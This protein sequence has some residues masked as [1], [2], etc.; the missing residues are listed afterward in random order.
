MLISRLGI[1]GQF[2]L[3]VLL[4]M[5]IFGSGVAYFFGHY[6][7]YEETIFDN[8]LKRQ[9]ETL[10]QQMRQ[11]AAY[12]ASNM[13]Y[14]IE[15]ALAQYDF[16]YI[17]A[18]IKKNA[19]EIP[20]F[21][22][23]YLKDKTGKVLLGS[24]EDS[25]GGA[26]LAAK[27]AADKAPLIQREAIWRGRP[28]LETRS[29]VAPDGE[30]WGSLLLGLH[31]DTLDKEIAHSVEISETVE[32]ALK[33]EQITLALASLAAFLGT[34]VILVVIVRYVTTPIRSL[35]ASVAGISQDMAQAEI[36]VFGR[37]DE[38][39]VLSR[40]FKE[41]VERIRSYISDLTEMNLSLERKVAER[42]LDLERKADELAE[43]NA[44]IIDGITCAQEVQK[45]ILPS[46]Q[47]LRTFLADSFV[48]W[49]PK[50]IVGGDFYWFDSFPAGSLVAVVD[51]TGHGVP[52]AL[53]SMAAHSML[54]EIVS[55]ENCSQPDRILG[56][57]HHALRQ[58]F[59][60]KE[61]S[62]TNH[63]G[64]DISLCFI[65]HDES[66]IV[67]SGTRQDLFFIR[68][69]ALNRVRGDNR[70]LGFKAEPEPEF[71]RHVV[72]VTGKTC[73]YLVTDGFTDQLGGAHGISF[74]RSR[75]HALALENS[76]KPLAGQESEFWAA[77]QDYKGSNDQLDDITLLAFTV[78][79][80]ESGV[81]ECA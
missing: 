49:R 15:R 57:L 35:T 28:V 74:G 75:L 70:V 3:P 68:D 36:P 38:I 27:M 79:T 44:K 60:A 58:S 4:I 77:L 80:N 51:C 5:V 54:R 72:D 63:H 31:Y 24:D 9:D 33:R 61:S 66:R 20:D 71:T 14:V 62:E 21:A 30:E 8:Q 81:P 52:G 42:T 45:S 6:E 1:R 46:I 53:R 78:G 19:A 11:Q 37:E 43:T 67:F 22:Y 59:G 16:S 2:L 12:A 41:M 48:L 18:V 47:T 65:A 25:A 13:V 73:F 69:G 26:P 32:A 7:S 56:E 40:T 76:L 39:G 55:A 34:V 50:D 23:V 29:R 17:Q 64:L 10:R